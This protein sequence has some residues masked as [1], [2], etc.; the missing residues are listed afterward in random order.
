M[1]KSVACWALIAFGV[2]GPRLYAQS[3]A[4]PTVDFEYFRTKVQPI[5]LA[6]RPGHARCIDC[7][8]DAGRHPHL[9]PLQPNNLFWTEDESRKN[10]AEFS[11]LVVP[12]SL[13][14]KLLV[15]PLAQ[16]AGGDFDHGGGKHFLSQTNREWLVLKAWVMGSKVAPAGPA[17]KVRVLQTNFA[18]DTLSIIDPVT[19]KV[20]STIPGIILGHGVAVSPDGRHIYESDEKESTLDV[21]DVQAQMFV[22]RIPLS[23]HPNNLSISKDG[24]F[25]YISIT[26][27]AGAVDV[28]DTTSMTLAKTIPTGMLIHNTYLTPDGK[29]A[30]A[31]SI[32]GN[33]VAVI[34]T[35]TNEVVRKITAETGV[36]PMAMSTNPDGSTKW[37]FIQLTDIDGFSV[38]DFATGK[39]VKRIMYPALPAGQKKLPPAGEVSHG[40]GVTPDGNTVVACSRVDSAVYSYSLPDL[41]FQGK[42]ELMGKGSGWLS[43]L[44]DSSRAYVANTITNDVSVIDIK[45]MKEVARIPV[46]EAPRRSTVAMLP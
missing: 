14:S 41:A 45:T 11:K 30:L 44:P 4:E 20:V 3:A 1:H 8:A 15:H 23:G 26:S 42:A 32:R 29:F 6:D 16:A 36:R 35:K 19:N 25:V 18:G 31:G 38:V 43:I 21:A 17:N 37:L 24:R 12:G 7:H 34:D 33:A 13:K 40:I 10:F 2:M 46:G 9:E 27:G 5:F 39:E 22:K 28:V